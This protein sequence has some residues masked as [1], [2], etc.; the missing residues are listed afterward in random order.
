MPRVVNVTTELLQAGHAELEQRHRWGCSFEQAMADP[1]RSRLVRAMAVGICLRRRLF[2][3]SAR[4]RAA[5]TQAR[6]QALRH[7]LGIDGKAAA[8]GEQPERD[9]A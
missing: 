8:A 6:T 2:T 4:R 9:E 3:K 1:V 5:A 7:R